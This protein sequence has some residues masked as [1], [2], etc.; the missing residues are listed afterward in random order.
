MRHDLPSASCRATRWPAPPSGILRALLVALV[1]W[2]TAVAWAQAPSFVARVDR[3]QVPVDDSFIYEVTLSIEGGRLDGYTAPDFKGFRVLGEHPS[4]STQIQ[5]GG[6]GMFSQT[7]YSWR[8]ELQPEK[9][10]SFTIEPARARTGGKLLKTDAVQ[11]GVVAAVGGRRGAPAVRPPTGGTFADPAPDDAASGSFLRVVADKPRAYVGEAVTVTW[12]L[13]LTARQD[14]YQ[15]VIEPRT[16]GFWSEDLP[17]PGGGRGLTLTQETYEGKPYL[18]A[19]L[20]RKALFPLQTGKLAVTPLESEISQVDF[21]GSTM[22]TQRL[23][24]PQ[25]VI[26]AVPVPGEGQPEGF[27]PAAVGK[28]QLAARADR[29]RVAVGEAV[30]LT[31]TISGQG[32]LRRLPTPKLGKLEGWKA[33]EP[34]V[35]VAVEP[36]ETVSGTKSVEYLLLPE[37]PGKTTI[38]AFA[39]AYFDPAARRYVVEKTAP[40]PIEVTSDGPA[41]GAGAPSG[42]TAT[43]AG[44][45]E[46]VLPVEVRPPR[47]RARLRRDLGTTLYKSD[48][49]VG[50]LAAPPLAFGLTILVGRVRERLGQ[51]TERG[52]RRKLRR[53]VRKRLRAAEAHLENKQTG[54]FYIEIERVMR[55]F[56]SAKLGRTVAGLPRDELRALLAACGLGGELSEQVITE[57]E[58]CDRARFAPGSVDETEMRAD[59]ARAE[60]II[61]QIEKAKLRPDG[62]A[63]A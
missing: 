62:G 57:L 10:G 1:T 27:D 20:M 48:L 42:L 5:M 52:R 58:E 11:V 30:T 16:D 41:G 61:L 15:T 28:F 3:T 24:A 51:E 6:G 55:E 13:Y 2:T 25:L 17:I 43:A 34:K 38:P 32:N 49:F 26:D 29:D 54:P 56:L 36:G 7:V 46:N 59:L 63:L 60:E 4:Q 8:Y 44:G 47:A 21:F 9:E 22:R 31:L 40:V 14:K 50:A 39:F 19:P 35:Q 18:V 33:Y 37:R 12:Y 53:L 45:V 23:K